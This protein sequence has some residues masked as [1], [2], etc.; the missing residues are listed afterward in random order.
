MTGTLLFALVLVFASSSLF[1]VLPSQAKSYEAIHIG[2]DGNVE[3]SSAPIVRLDDS[4]S[5][6]ADIY[7]SPLVLERNS[8]V[9]D[10]GGYVLEGA[11]GGI[12]LNVTCSNVTVRNIVAVNWEVGILGAYNN[13][14]IS[15]AP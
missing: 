3:P 15:T 7:N 2:P 6:S 13:N 4:Y 12:A 11:K 9:F 8:V 5:L 14:S 10:G 1:C